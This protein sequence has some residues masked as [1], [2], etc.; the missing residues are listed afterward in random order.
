MAFSQGFDVDDFIDNVVYYDRKKGKEI[1]S[2]IESSDSMVETSS[3]DSDMESLDTVSEKSSKKRRIGSTPPFNISYSQAVRSTVK[4]KPKTV[5]HAKT[6]P[7][8]PKKYLVIMQAQEVELGQQNPIKIQRLI[9]S[10]DYGTPK[11][12][13]GTRRGIII[14]CNDSFQ[15]KSILASQRLGDWQVKC[16]VPKSQESSIGCIYNTPIDLTEEEVLGVLKDYKV[17]KVNRLT[18]YDSASQTRKPSKTMK[19]YFNTAQLVENIN[20]GFTR[21]KVKPFIPRPIQYHKMPMKVSKLKTLPFVEEN[22]ETVLK[23]EEL[24]RFLRKHVTE[25]DKAIRIDNLKLELSKKKELRTVDANTNKIVLYEYDE[26]YI[27]LLQ[28]K[29]L[30]H[31]D[32]DDNVYCEYCFQNISSPHLKPLDWKH[33][34]LLKEWYLEIPLELQ[35]IFGNL[36]STRTHCEDL[37]AVKATYSQE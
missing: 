6:P 11:W 15:F 13:N 19:L 16:T 23:V 29:T 10:L 8:K 25:G 28:L 4:R 12:V 36:L 31:Q 14:E 1:S 27:D 7:P 32:D 17:T 21:Y 3:Q 20:I 30:K 37:T 22:S 24:V 35:T 26:D 34:D 5:V 33:F 2:E 18:Y 9:Q